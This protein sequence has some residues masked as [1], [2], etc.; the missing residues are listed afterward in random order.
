MADN[1]TASL[2]VLGGPLAGAQ[3]ELPE[4]GTLTIGS[5]PDSTLYLDLLAVSPFHARVVVDAGR[6][7]VHDTGSSRTVH[8]NDNAI[9]PEGTELRNGDILWLGAPGDDE[10]VMLQCILPKRTAP[11]TLTPPGVLSSGATPT[12]EIE[13]VALWATETATETPAGAEAETATETEAATEAATE[14]D[15]TEA[16]TAAQEAADAAV[17]E[18]VAEAAAAV[19]DDAPAAWSEPEAAAFDDEAIVVGDDAVPA[20]E[21]VDEPEPVSAA[22]GHV[23]VSFAEETPVE[24]EASAPEAYVVDE[25]EDLAEVAPT[26]LMSSPDEVADAVEPGYRETVSL[27]APPEFTPE[28]FEPPEAPVLE[29]APVEEP[30]VEAT[31]EF[32][33][34]PPAP[35]AEPEPAPAPEPTPPPAAK[36]KEAPAGSGP[37]PAMSRPAAWQTSRPQSPSAS[38]RLAG[39]SASQR[40]KARPTPARAAEPAPAAEGDE[41]QD[42]AGSR[43]PMLLAAGGFVAVLALAGG[44]YFAWQTLGKR[45][46][47]APAA[48]PAPVARASEPTPPPMAATPEPIEAVA[49]SATATPEPVDTQPAPAATPTPRP[50]PTPRATPT[51]AAAA[52]TPTPGPS[53]EQLRAQ[54]AAAQAQALVGQAEAALAARQYDA[55]LSHL[56]G[57]LRLEPGNARATSLRAD[58]SRRRAFARRRFVAGRTAID[59]EKTRKDKERG[60]LVGFD[61]DAREPDFLGRIDFEM[62]PATGIQSNDAWTLKIFVQNQ[63]AKPIRVTGL[64]VATTVNGAGGGGPVTPAARE[65]APQ[66]RVLVGESTGTWVAG[67]TAWVA[68]ATLTAPKNETLRNSLTWR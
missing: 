67:T 13:T 28:M 4:S 16:D 10:V 7:T 33:P 22:E 62:S 52:P 17:A 12:P 32:E 30:P 2:T 6:I 68:E 66:Q 53:P 20:P 25:D 38:Q 14:A 43:H 3:C 23:P 15:E 42:E 61:T 31:P 1:K 24:A 34:P 49:P 50:T 8:V 56:D 26:L 46:A 60:G 57:A 44:G 63:G 65:I 48:T 21:T 40:Q 9:G 59:S 27:E 36:P 11:P 51:P 58:A 41:L 35:A 64:S 39:P 45:P 54:Q 18:A 5:S 19:A 37:R 47:A 29:A 55:A